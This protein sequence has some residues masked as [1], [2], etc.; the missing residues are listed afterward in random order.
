MLIKLQTQEKNLGNTRKADVPSDP[1]G[2]SY[3]SSYRRFHP[4]VSLRT[5]P[6]ASA[7]RANGGKGP[8]SP[9]CG[10][11]RWTSGT[12]F[13]KVG[14]GPRIKGQFLFQASLQWY[15]VPSGLKNL[16]VTF[17]SYAISGSKLIATQFAVN[18]RG[19]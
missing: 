17:S 11:H 13:K 12:T 5:G 14:N 2:L 18:S 16:K 6:S 8:R 10:T 19:S 3:F 1:S 9:G 4:Q 15:I 7:L